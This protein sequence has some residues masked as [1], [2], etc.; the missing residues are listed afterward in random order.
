MVATAAGAGFSQ[1]MVLICTLGIEIQ[2]NGFGKRR[3]VE[4]LWGWRWDIERD[5]KGSLRKD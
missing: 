3:K 4:T 1:L 5:V 2:P